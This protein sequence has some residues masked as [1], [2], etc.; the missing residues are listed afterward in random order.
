MFL[1]ATGHILHD[2]TSHPN[3]NLVIQCLCLPSAF[4]HVRNETRHP[5]KPDILQLPRQAAVSR[6]SGRWQLTYLNTDKEKSAT[7]QFLQDWREETAVNYFL[8]YRDKHIS[9]DSFRLCNSKILNTIQGILVP[10]EGSNQKGL[11]VE[12]LNLLWNKKY[13][14]WPYYGTQ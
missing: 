10:G 9:S 13:I 4:R 11:I 14:S 12:L 7:E 5:E 3:Q 8:D 6:I 1:Q 2:P